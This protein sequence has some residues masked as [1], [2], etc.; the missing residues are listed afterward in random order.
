MRATTAL[1][2]NWIARV[3]G[4]NSTRSYGRAV[5]FELGRLKWLRK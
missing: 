1:G 5:A 3:A 4:S 2:K